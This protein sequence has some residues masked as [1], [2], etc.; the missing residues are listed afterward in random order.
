MWDL[1]FPICNFDLEPI[2]HEQHWNWTVRNTASFILNLDSLWRL[3]EPKLTPSVSLHW[4]NLSMVQH[5]G[6]DR[7]AYRELWWPSDSDKRTKSQQSQRNRHFN[8]IQSGVDCDKS[9]PIPGSRGFLR[10]QC[11]FVVQVHVVVLLQLDF[12]L[13][14]QH[15]AISLI[16]IKLCQANTLFCWFVLC[17]FWF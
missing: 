8:G 9:T 11:W 5:G 1:L 2:I 4:E 17:Q 6:G 13:S 12:I 7:W 14:I 10:W 15:K 16:S 3:G